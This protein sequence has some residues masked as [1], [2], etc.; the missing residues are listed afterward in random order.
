MARRPAQYGTAQVKKREPIRPLLVLLL[1]F[2]GGI[3]LYLWL[4]KDSA[5]PLVAVAE[6][7]A[8]ESAEPAVRAEAAEPE[9]EPVD[10]LGAWWYDAENLLYDAFQGLDY[11][12]QG[13][14]GDLEYAVA[15]LGQIQPRHEQQIRAPFAAVLGAFDSAVAAC[16]NGNAA[17]VTGAESTA[18]SQ[19]KSLLRNLEGFGV[20]PSSLLS[21]L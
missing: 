14:C 6:D 11:A 8:E 12:K 19:V 15:E 17:A 13:E 4:Q 10:D 18:K 7:V 3:L 1:I 16:R 9:L 21:D 20:S 2:A 5:D